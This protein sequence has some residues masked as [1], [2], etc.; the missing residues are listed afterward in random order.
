MTKEFTLRMPDEIHSVLTRLKE[1]F[2]VAITS[3]ILDYVARGLIK[4]GY[5]RIDINGKKSPRVLPSINMIPEELKFCD[6]DSCEIDPMVSNA[7][8]RVKIKKG[9][10]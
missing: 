2:G 5:I 1:S 6:G 10:E 3:K 4:D 9:V 8:K 7:F